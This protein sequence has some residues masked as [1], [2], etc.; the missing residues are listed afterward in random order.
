MALRRCIGLKITQSYQFLSMGAG[1]QALYLAILGICDDDGIFYAEQA[2]KIAGRRKNE[3]NELLSNNYIVEVDAELDVYYVKDWH[4][5]NSLKADRSTP[6]IHR[7]ALIKAIPNI[8]NR[9]FTA[10]KNAFGVQIDSASEN[11]SSE[12]KPEEVRPNEC[13]SSE[14]K[15]EEPFLED[16]EDYC[17]EHGYDMTVSLKFMRLNQ[18]E[19][20][21][22]DLKSKTWQEIFEK[23]YSMEKNKSDI[24]SAEY[25]EKLQKYKYERVLWF[26]N[27]P[28]RLPFS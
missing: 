8:K 13:K 21:W 11:K 23:F 19:Y 5:F 9:L 10:K 7:E 28:K 15:N 2:R 26:D 17:K 18:A 25:S 3:F 16:V 22:K 20:K 12:V 24:N 6:S 27:N 1:A 14:V 4:S